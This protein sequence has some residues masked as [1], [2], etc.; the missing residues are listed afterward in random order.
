MG[1]RLPQLT[2]YCAIACQLTVRPISSTL[3]VLLTLEQ[4]DTVQNIGL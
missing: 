3:M 1:R 2:F 4:G